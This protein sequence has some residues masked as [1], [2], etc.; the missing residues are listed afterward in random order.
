MSLLAIYDE[1][2]GDPVAMLQFHHDEIGNRAALLRAQLA[3]RLVAG[4]G[5]DEH[6]FALP[7]MASYLSG[8][9]RL[10]LLGFYDAAIIEAE[11]R[12]AAVFGG[13]LDGM[14]A[15]LAP[16]ATLVELVARADA[17]GLF[18]A[19]ALDQPGRQRLLASL[20]ELAA[21]RQAIDARNRDQGL[22][23][24]VVAPASGAL[25]GGP[26]AAHT[27]PILGYYLAWGANLH[28]LL[29][30][31]VLAVTLILAAGSAATPPS[32]RS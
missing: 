30:D 4:L 1:L 7:A 27:E 22:Q 8:A 24:T 31:G 13:R 12:L 21:K 19:P 2:L 16:A 20:H 11:A 25:S 29:A 5:L 28:H 17:G 18:S 32:A 10:Y 9:M 14:A 3:A 26:G 6:S 23:I 15:A